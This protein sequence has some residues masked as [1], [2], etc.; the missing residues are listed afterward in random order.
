MNSCRDL[1]ARL[2]SMFA[3][4]RPF[5][6]QSDAIF[7]CTAQNRMRSYL[8]PRDRDTGFSRHTERFPVLRFRQSPVMAPISNTVPCLHE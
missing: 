4:P 1:T 6:N 8:E 7:K 3:A 2:M 5:A